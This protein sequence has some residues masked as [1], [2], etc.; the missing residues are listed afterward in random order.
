MDSNTK[1]GLTADG[2]V[3]Q[4]F[5]SV[6]RVEIGAFNSWIF[7]TTMFSCDVLT[8]QRQWTRHEYVA[9][10]SRGWWTSTDCARGEVPMNIQGTVACYL[11][12]EN[13]LGGE[14]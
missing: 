8:R 2:E 3:T 12:D 14:S 5:G 13:D 10:G 9:D 1:F 6:A 7:K 4:D 11:G